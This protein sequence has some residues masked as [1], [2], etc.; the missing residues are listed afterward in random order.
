MNCWCGAEAVK[1][2]ESV[3]F[4]ES[5]WP[6][7]DDYP[8]VPEGKYVCEGCFILIPASSSYHACRD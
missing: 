4:C 2:W 7:N 3:P 6:G 1:V 8:D 5:H